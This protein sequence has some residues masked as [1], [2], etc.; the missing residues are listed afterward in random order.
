MRIQNVGQKKAKESP[1]EIIIQVRI[2]R[3]TRNLGCLEGCG[4]GAF[5]MSHGR[6]TAKMVK[7]LL[8]LISI[9]YYNIQVYNYFPGN[10][11]PRKLIDIITAVHPETVKGPEP[12]CPLDS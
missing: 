6:V 12:L 1:A 3:N 2:R 8:N 9:T 10:E 4:F 11:S 7:R 5:G